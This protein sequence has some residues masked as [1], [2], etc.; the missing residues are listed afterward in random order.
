MTKIIKLK[1]EKKKPTHSI[2]S[3][4]L[5]KALSQF[6]LFYHD[7][8]QILFRALERERHCKAKTSAPAKRISE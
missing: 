7:T 8:S 3:I 4:I 5:T 6:L 1:N 2:F